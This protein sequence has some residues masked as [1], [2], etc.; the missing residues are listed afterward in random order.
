MSDNWQCILT[1]NEYYDGPVFGIAEFRDVPHV[2]ERQW[3]PALDEY[4]AY[5][6]LSPIEPDL[7]DLVMEDWEIWLRWVAAC[8][9]GE[10]DEK[11]H[12]ALPEEQGRH[13]EISELIGDRLE[14]KRGGPIKQFGNLEIVDGELRVQWADTPPPASL[15]ESD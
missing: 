4:G 3:D 5:F 1:V 2:Y 7:L 8:K 10:V 6:L 15:A 14:L 11:T 9:R 12:P 13:Q